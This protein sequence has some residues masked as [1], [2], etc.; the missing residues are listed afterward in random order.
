MTRP[1]KSKHG[2]ILQGAG[3]GGKRHIKIFRLA[4]LKMHYGGIGHRR[5]KRAGRGAGMLAAFGVPLVMKLI[6]KYL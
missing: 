1:T 6:D 5:H 2:L 4:R 3:P